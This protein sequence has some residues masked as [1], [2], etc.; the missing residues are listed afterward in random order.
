MVIGTEDVNCPAE[1][2]DLIARDLDKADL[3]Y[4]Y[5][6]GFDHNTF[7]YVA[8]PDFVDRVVGYIEIG[9]MYAKKGEW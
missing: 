8:S 9:A 4:H 7:A 6:K 2:V 3:S 1:N 5:E